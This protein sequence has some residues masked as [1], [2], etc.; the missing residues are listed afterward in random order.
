MALA[1]VLLACGQPAS[2]SRSSLALSFYL[3]L[4]CMYAVGYPLGH[5]ALLGAFSK[6]VSGQRS[7][8]GA[9]MGIFAASGSVGRVVFPLLSG[10]C[11]EI[12]GSDAAVFGAVGA[13]LAGLAVGVWVNRASIND[14]IA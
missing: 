4:A 6:V 7:H 8:Q 9:N 5:T 3:S 13:L 2:D 11:A 14:A 12:L 10:L 1:C